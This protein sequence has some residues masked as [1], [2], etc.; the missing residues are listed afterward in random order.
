MNREVGFKYDVVVFM[1]REALYDRRCR[2][3]VQ[4]FAAQL[5]KLTPVYYIHNV[6]SEDNSIEVGMSFSGVKTF[7][8]S[9]QSGIATL[10]TVLRLIKRNRMEKILIVICDPSYSTILPWVANPYSAIYFSTQEDF[11]E[12]TAQCALINDSD[13]L[14]DIKHTLKYCSGIL[15]N[16]RAAAIRFRDDA[17]ISVPVLEV[18]Q[19]NYNLVLE[20]LNLRPIFKPIAGSYKKRILF[21]YDRN[22]C[23][24]SNLRENLDAFGLFS[25]HYITYMDGCG[26]NIISQ[27]FINSFDAIAVHYSVRLSKQGHL[28]SEMFERIRVYTGLKVLFIQDEYD[29]LSCTYDYLEKIDFDILYTV[30]NIE[31]AHK[32]YPKERFP[33]LRI[34]P[35]LTGY[36]PYNIRGF[37]KPAME[38]RT[39]DVFYRG[40]ELPFE[41]GTLGREKFEIGKKFKEACVRNHVNLRLDLDSDNSKRIYGDLWYH[42]LSKSKTMLGTESG[43][44]VFDFNGDLSKLIENDIASGLTYD[45]IYEKRL[46]QSEQEWKVNTISPKVFESIILGTVPIL[47]E[48]EYSGI[49]IPGRHYV[50]LK[51]DFSNFEEVIAVVKDDKKLKEISETAYKEIVENPIYSYEYFIRNLFDKIIDEEVLVIKANEILVT[52]NFHKYSKE[53][54]DGVKYDV[55]TNYPVGYTPPMLFSSE[56]EMHYDFQIVFQS[57]VLRTKRYLKNKL[58]VLMQ[59]ERRYISNTFSK[60]FSALKFDQ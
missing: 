33:H 26:N 54:I 10:Q 45:E 44:N 25:R 29:N 7:D 43:S 46:K 38:E 53:A 37:F 52:G 18:E 58:L 13:P 41:Y 22:S 59:D 51:K 49:L 6:A 3:S 4:N 32:L 15:T 11:E 47:Y 8:S 20:K 16:S 12:I 30:I 50:S 57:T 60:L 24:V 2:K 40:R 14:G 39:C 36:V 28:S 17:G 27:E 1:G 19:G 5:E 34:V 55:L 48:G 56:A 31:S 9:S 42:V 23:H 21:L 35:I